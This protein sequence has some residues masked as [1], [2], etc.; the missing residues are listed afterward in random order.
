MGGLLPIGRKMTK[1]TLLIYN[2]RN[3]EKHE[4][5]GEAFDTKHNVLLLIYPIKALTGS[6]IALPADFGGL[7]RARP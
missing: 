5:L 6:M 2:D 1:P 3:G 7:E 4:C